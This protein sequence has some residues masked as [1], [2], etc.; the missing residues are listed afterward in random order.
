[1]GNGLWKVPQLCKSAN[2]FGGL[3]QLLI[4]AGFAQLLGKQKALSTLTHKAG[5]TV[6]YLRQRQNQGRE[7]KTSLVYRMVME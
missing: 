1:M 2:A 7:Q 5:G 3:R 4:D 6:I